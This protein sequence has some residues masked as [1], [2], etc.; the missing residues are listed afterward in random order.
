MAM[1]GLMLDPVTHAAHL[2]CATAMLTPTEFRLLAALAARP[3]AT[4]RRR[5]LREAAWPHGGI[6]HDNTLEA[7]V[8]RVRRKLRSLPGAPTVK[9]VHGV[10]YSLA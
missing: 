7:H 2:G 3:G 1:G 4:L 9:T 8:A 6:V 5:E 10:G